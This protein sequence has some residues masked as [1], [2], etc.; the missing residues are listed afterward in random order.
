MGPEFDQHDM[1]MTWLINS[2]SFITMGRRVFTTDCGF[3]GLGSQEMERHD[4]VCLTLE[5]EPPMILRQVRD[6]PMR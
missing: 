4:T 5:S 6:D 1:P 2:I 3:L